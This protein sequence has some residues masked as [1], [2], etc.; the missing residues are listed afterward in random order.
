MRNKCSDC[1]YQE[2]G[3]KAIRDKKWQKNINDNDYT[4]VRVHKC[5]C[6]DADTWGAKTPITEKNVCIGRKEYLEKKNRIKFKK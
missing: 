2:G 3:E 4:K 1:P 6:I 5:H